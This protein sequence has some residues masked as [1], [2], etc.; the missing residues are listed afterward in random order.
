MRKKWIKVND[1]SIGQYSDN[2]NIRL[3]TSMF[4][5]YLY[6]FKEHILLSKEKKTVTGTNATIR[7]NKKLIFKKITFYLDHVY[8]KS[9]AYL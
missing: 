4:R 1:L 7:R 5:S 6:D 2:R 9:I 8:Q 3:K